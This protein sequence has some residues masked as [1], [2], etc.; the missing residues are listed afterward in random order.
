MH[1][2]A[3]IGVPLDLGAG[4]R[5]VDMGPSAIRYAGLCDRLNALGHRVDD[6]GNLHAPL[7][8]TIP[9]P[10]VNE[11]LRYLEPIVAVN[12]A[13]AGRVA[14]MVAAGLLPLVLGGDHSIAIGS[15][16]GSA[17]CRRTT[18]SRSSHAIS[19]RSARAG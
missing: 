16:G 8:E 10:A 15:V 14:E 13:L 18:P 17:R 7:A 3:I 1:N 4:R 11:K 6:G 12:R 2:I 19:T 9:T 5:G